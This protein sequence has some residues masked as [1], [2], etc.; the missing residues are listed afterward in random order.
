VPLRLVA[1]ALWRLR[2]APWTWPLIAALALWPPVP[3]AVQNGNPAI[4]AFAFGCLAVSTGWTGP[5]ILFKPTLAPFALIG[6]RR[7]RWWR[8]R[9]RRPGGGAVGRGIRS[10]ARRHPG[11]ASR[12]ARRRVVDR[13]DF[14]PRTIGHPTQGSATESAVIGRPGTVPRR[15]RPQ[16]ARDRRTTGIRAIPGRESAGG[17]PATSE[18]SRRPCRIGADPSTSRLVTSTPPDGPLPPRRL[19]RATG[20]RF[21]CSI[22]EL[23]MLDQGE[24]RPPVKDLG[25]RRHCRAS[26][27]PRRAAGSRGQRYELVL[28]GGATLL[29]RGVISRPTRDADVVTARDDG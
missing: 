8:A 1:C 4:W 16:P 17:D 13:A 5:L 28:V 22:R 29:L 2:P 3:E 11:R 14:P 25:K 23:D 15:W 9:H 18:R 7:G 19:S 26:D 27:R 21:S 12:E 10:G 24:H 20:E 6:G